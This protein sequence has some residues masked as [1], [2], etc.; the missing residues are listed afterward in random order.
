MKKG[1]NKLPQNE[2]LNISIVMPRF[3][4]FTYSVYKTDKIGYCHWAKGLNMII[5]KDGVKIELSSD[6]VQKIVKSLPR[7]IGG[8]Y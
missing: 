8:R 1:T 7:T 5:E 6:E 3:K 4:V 2:A